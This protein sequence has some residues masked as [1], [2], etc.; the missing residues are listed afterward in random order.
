MAPSGTPSTVCYLNLSDILLKVRH[1][2]V[3]VLHMAQHDKHKHQFYHMS[4]DP[5]DPEYLFF[6]ILS[7]I[8]KPQ[9]F[10]FHQ[11]CKNS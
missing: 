6:E 9:D 2:E 5:D 11:K 7:V 8:L 1:C 3:T 10:K 4:G